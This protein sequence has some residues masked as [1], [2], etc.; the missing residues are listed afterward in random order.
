M[1]TFEQPIKAPGSARSVPNP[2]IIKF[3]LFLVCFFSPSLLGGRWG[4]MRFRGYTVVVDQTITWRRRRRQQVALR[5]QVHPPPTYPTTADWSVPKWVKSRWELLPLMKG[6]RGGGSETLFID[7]I[8]VATAR[9][10]KGMWFS[11]I[12][13][14]RWR[15]GGGGG[16]MG[17]RGLRNLGSAKLLARRSLSRRP[18]VII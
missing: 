10:L 2:K 16:N 1:S 5:P 3:F 17:E 14:R 7:S 12:A 13:G 6:G 8:L 4:Q 11:V 18:I 15:G 9:K